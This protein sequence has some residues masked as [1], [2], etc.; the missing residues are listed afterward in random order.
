MGDCA[1]FSALAGAQGAVAGREE[2]GE[3][4]RRVRSSRNGGTFGGVI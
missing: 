1:Q 2:F 4:E 3:R